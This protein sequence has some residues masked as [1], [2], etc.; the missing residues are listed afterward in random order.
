MNVSYSK[1]IVRREKLDI[2]VDFPI[3]N[4]ADGDDDLLDMSDIVLGP[5]DGD[6]LKYELYAI[7]NHMGNLGGGHY[8]AYAK[9]FNNNKWYSFNDSSTAE[10]K[11]ISSIITS[12]AYVLFYKRV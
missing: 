11:N 7:S 5:S 2:L 4:V 3:G 12:H 6:S 10:V 1:S 8:T 9:N